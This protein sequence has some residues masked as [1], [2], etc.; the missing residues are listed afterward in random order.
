MSNSAWIAVTAP[1]MTAV[2]KPKRK[3]P[4]AA[5]VARSNAR[6]VSYSSC[7]LGWLTAIA[8]STT[9]AGAL[10]HP[11]GTETHLPRTGLE[12]LP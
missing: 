3:P 11:D 8:S 9:Q 7:V 6:P 10:R 4:S 12:R 2:S 1:L 5:T